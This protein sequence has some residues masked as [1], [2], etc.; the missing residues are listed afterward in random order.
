MAVPK[1]SKNADWP[2]DFIRMARSKQWQL[3][4]MERGNAPPRGSVLRN[5]EREAFALYT[6]VLHNS[7][8][9]LFTPAGREFRFD[10]LE[11]LRGKTEERHAAKAESERASLQFPVA[12]AVKHLFTGQ[13]HAVQEEK[14]N[15]RRGRNPLRHG[16][17]RAAHR[18]QAGEQDRREEQRNEAVGEDAGKHG[19]RDGGRGRG[20]QATI[21]PV[22]KRWGG[23]PPPQAVVE[24]PRR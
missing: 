22:A 15:D 20:W 12:D 19:G 8:Y 21:L 2:I 16:H 3:R 11:Q 10:S 5:P 24:G 17:R 23:G 14:K 7:T 4:S 13:A 6:G 1:Y 18:Q 9:V